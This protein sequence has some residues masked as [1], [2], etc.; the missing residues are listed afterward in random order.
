MGIWLALVGVLAIAAGLAETRRVRR[1]RSRGTRTWGLIVQAPGG[2]G[3]PLDDPPRRT[4]VQYSL[5]DGRVLERL[6]PEPRRARALRPG[7]Q[8]V[9]W[10]D[11][12]DPG[13]L[14]VYGRP[15]RYADLA[16]VAGGAACV[17]AGLALA[18]SGH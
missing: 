17:L 10:Y 1:L 12:E 5:A 18:A 13:E 8:V 3:D 9:V 16:F 11:P 7:Q 2:T 4:L 6:Y 14:L 15:G